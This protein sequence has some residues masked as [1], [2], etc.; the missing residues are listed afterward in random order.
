V[1][2]DDPPPPPPPPPAASII[3]DVKDDTGRPVT[4]AT[5]F[6]DDQAVKYDLDGKPVEL[7]P[8]PHTITVQRNDGP[9]VRAS[10]SIVLGVEEVGHA[11]HL[12]FPKPPEPPPQDEAPDAAPLVPRIVVG[13]GMV[14]VITGT[15]LLLARP[16]MAP[17]C[18]RDSCTRQADETDATYKDDRSTAATN[19]DLT[20]AGTTV[21][22]A[23]A[24]VA[25]GGLLWYFLAHPPRRMASVAPWF[26][27]TSGGVSIRG[28]F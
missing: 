16:T 14:G 9:H 5:L 1:F 15:V 17:N 10:E 28:A 11:V 4:T 27:T 8:G 3:V 24:G 21:L 22:L 20:T 26:A 6:V 23:G 7:P 25:V 13:V 12:V 18:S 2:W 19:R